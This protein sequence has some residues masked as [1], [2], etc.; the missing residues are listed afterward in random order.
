MFEE[1]I[2]F[3]RIC[4]LDIFY[5]YTFDR[6][7]NI[8]L[9]LKNVMFV[10]CIVQLVLGGV[11]CGNQ[12]N[13]RIC[14]ICRIC[15]LIGECW[16]GVDSLEIL[17]LVELPGKAGRSWMTGMSEMTGMSGMSEMPL[18]GLAAGMPGMPLEGLG[19]HTDG[20]LEDLLAFVA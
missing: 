8:S 4:H 12:S 13:C 10:V 17:E 3:W 18:K 9:S 2:L 19:W 20:F 16:N 1:I 14:R 15:I 7:H 5:R 6:Y 11:F